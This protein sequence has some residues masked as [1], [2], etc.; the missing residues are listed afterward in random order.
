MSRAQSRFVLILCIA[1]SG[2]GWSDVAGSR[3]PFD[4][5]RYPRAEIISFSSDAEPR[6]HEFIVSHVEKIRRDLKVAEEVRVN[7]RETVAIYEMPAGIPLETVIEHYRKVVA[8]DDVRFSC[9]GR[10]CGRSAQWAN[11]VFGQAILYGPDANQFYLAGQ[12]TE[13]LVSLYVIER[14]NRRVLVMIRLLAT[15]D[16]VAVSSGLRMVQTLGSLGHVVVKGA[17]P[18]VNGTLPV[19]AIEVLQGI[20]KH[21]GT[22]RKETIYVVCHLYAPGPADVTI[23]RSSAC[24]EAATVALKAQGEAEGGPTLV[25]FGAGPL[26]PREERIG[27]IELVLPHRRVTD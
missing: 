2:N 23:K 9:R 14:G 24:A 4:F 22:L 6:E 27:R 21:L 13:G 18:A 17:I 16:N 12:R 11:Q 19:K 10:D 1:L 20:G 5:P 15:S 7:A 3:D 25:P 8:V 26:L